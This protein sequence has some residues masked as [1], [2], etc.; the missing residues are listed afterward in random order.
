VKTEAELLFGQRADGRIVSIFNVE[1]GLRCACV[2]P[3]CG[4]RLVAKKGALKAHHFAHA[5]EIDCPGAYET[6]LH[7]LGKQVILDVGK[8]MIPSVVVYYLEYEKLVYPASWAT[9][10]RVEKEIKWPDFQPDILAQWRS[11]RLAVEI[12]VTHACEREKIEAVWRSGLAMMEIDLSG[13]K[14]NASEKEIR[15]AVLRTAPREWIFNPRWESALDDFKRQIEAE[16]QARERDAMQR[17]MAEFNAKIPDDDYKDI[18]LEGVTMSSRY[19]RIRE[20]K[21]MAKVFCNIDGRYRRSTESFFCDSKAGSSYAVTMRKGQD[22]PDITAEL[23][24]QIHEQLMIVN[25]GHNGIWIGE[26]AVVGPDWGEADGIIPA[27]PA[28]I[29]EGRASPQNSDAEV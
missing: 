17:L 7:K 24:R 10:D 2:C 25:G 1:S 26:T 8:V 27:E 18:E 6:T 21:I 12:K 19:G 20:I 3:Q 14:R 28:T 4:G 23:G 5:A 22:Y 15:D 9:F 16:R 13:V 29:E 11:R